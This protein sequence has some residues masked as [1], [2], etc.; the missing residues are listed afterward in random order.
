MY[1]GAATSHKIFFSCTSTFSSSCVQRFFSKMKLVETLLRF[2]LKQT[3]LENQLH[4]S[5][6]SP[7]EDFHDT[8]FQDFVDAPKQYN[9]DMRINL[10]LLPIFLCLYSIYFCY[11]SQYMLPFRMIFFFMICNALFFSSRIRNSPLQQD[12][13]VNFNK[14][15]IQ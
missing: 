8:I 13:F 15:L 7:E 11:H 1:F 2:Q 3:H 9:P 5:I 12:L 6:K 4:I 14:N 10:Q